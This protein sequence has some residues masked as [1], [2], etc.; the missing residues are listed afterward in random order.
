[1]TYEMAVQLKQAGFP[2]K[3]TKPFPGFGEFY[4]VGDSGTII[5]STPTNTREFIYY[6]TLDE[7]IE[8]IPMREKHLGTVNDAHFVLRKLVGNSPRYHAYMEDEDHPDNWGIEGFS[9]IET[10]PKV[11]VAKLYLALHKL[12]GN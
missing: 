10:D 12:H 2:Q 11:A 8:A 4:V 6:P 9:F 3:P 5:G 1:M 7:L